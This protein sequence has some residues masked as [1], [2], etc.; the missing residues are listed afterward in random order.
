MYVCTDMKSLISVESNSKVKC[1]QKNCLGL[2]HLLIQH[3]FK[4]ASQSH[5]FRQI[6]SPSFWRIVNDRILKD[7]IND[8]ILKDR[9][10][11]RSCRYPVFKSSEERFIF[12]L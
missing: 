3:C 9:I 8:R 11:P 1:R 7:R 5:P 4:K 12:V 10:S 2:G 6:A